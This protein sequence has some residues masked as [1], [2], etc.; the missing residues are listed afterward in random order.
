MKLHSNYLNPFQPFPEREFDNR[1][2]DR[3]PTAIENNLSRSVFSALANA[4][5]PA[6]LAAFLHSLVQQHG[7]PQ[8][9]D[10]MKAFAETLR[11]TDTSKI[12]FGLQTWPA[13]AIQEL[14]CRKKVL[15]GI[16][17]SH[18]RTWT[19][20]QRKAPINPQPDAWIYV[21]KQMLLVF[22]WKN[23]E[24][25]LDATQISAYAHCLGL[26]TENDNVPKA[27]VGMCLDSAEQAQAVQNACK[28]LVLDVPWDVVANALQDIQGNK[29]DLGSWLCHKA[30]EYVRWHIRP[31]YEG[32]QTIL[33][34]LNGP[35]TPDR[36]NHLRKLVERMGDELEKSADG[37][38]GAITFA[39]K[40]KESGNW[41]L[42]PGAGSAVYVNL[43]QGQELVQR[44]FLNRKV[45]A[46]L[47]FPFAE[48]QMPRIG[49]EYYLQ[50]TGG[51]TSEWDSVIAWNEAS[52]RH[53]DSAKSFERELAAWVPKAPFGSQMIVSAVR[54]NGKKR[55]WQGGGVD[56]I[57]APNSPPLTPEEAV[58]FLR[59]HQKKLWHFPRVEQDSMIEKAALQVRKPAL[60]LL[61]PLDA[62]KLALC[63]GDRQALQDYLQNVLKIVI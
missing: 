53:F 7:S 14:E 59:R 10:R 25:S 20:N 6:V 61:V 36:R 2:K 26:L 37:R 24:H 49:L 52:K 23:D 34:W 48:E 11:V 56:D 3:P 41:D 54:F 21:P 50:A 5:S 22:E 38:Q 16:S 60:S 63:G 32:V 29:S 35:D 57:T 17:S 45:K 9:Q 8:L 39:K 58:E 47:W 19:H 51:N 27:A 18:Q 43:M 44:P 42:K 4:D 46:V 28:D 33:A 12:E 1:G 13:L 15:I 55:T 31:P 40:E 62:N 30:A